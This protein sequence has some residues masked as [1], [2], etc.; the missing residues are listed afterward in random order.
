MVFFPLEIRRPQ[1]KSQAPELSPTLAARHLSGPQL[2]FTAKVK[3]HNRVLPKASCSVT[4][5]KEG[6]AFPSPEPR[7]LGTSRKSLP[8]TREGTKPLEDWQ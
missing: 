6:Q 7:G 4:K 8:D 2:L 1:D 5:V 3:V